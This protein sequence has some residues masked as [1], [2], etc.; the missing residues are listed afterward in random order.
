MCNQRKKLSSA[1]SAFS[2]P[3]SIWRSHLVDRKSICR[4][5]SCNVDEYPKTLDEIQAILQKT[6]EATSRR[7]KDLA[8]AF[9]HQIWR[10]ES[11]AQVEGK[12]RW[13][14]R[15]PTRKQWDSNIGRMSCDPKKTVEMDTHQQQRPSSFCV[16]SPLPIRTIMAS[17]PKPLQMYI[18]GVSGNI[19]GV[20]SGIPNYMAATVSAKARLRSQSAP[21]WC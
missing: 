16:A 7:E 20:S 12:T 5:E 10:N 14:D 18:H 2:G 19:A 17:K 11:E 6:K 1:E 9:S 15:W 8:R 4:E 21:T 13:V 3:N